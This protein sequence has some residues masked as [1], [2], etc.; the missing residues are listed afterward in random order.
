VTVENPTAV[1]LAALGFFV[2]VISV[3]LVAWLVATV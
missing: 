2:F 3:A 1:A